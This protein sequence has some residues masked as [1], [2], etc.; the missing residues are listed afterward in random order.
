MN[1]IFRTFMNVSG[2]MLMTAGLSSLALAGD[3]PFIPNAVP[4]LDPGSLGSALT[5]ASGAFFM[6]RGRRAPK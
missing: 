5:I 6:L 3:P 2:L 4:E 1:R